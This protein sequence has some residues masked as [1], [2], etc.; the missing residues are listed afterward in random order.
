L[1]FDGDVLLLVAVVIGGLATCLATYPWHGYVFPVGADA[2]VYIWWT[3]LAGQEGLSAV[4]DRPGVPALA[5]ALRTVVP[6]GTAAIIAALEI[7]LT[8]ALALAAAA[9]VRAAGLGRTAWLSVGVLSGAFALHL[10]VG[11]VATLLAAVLVVTA[12]AALSRA[13][14]R[15]VVAAAGLLGVAG[16]A[17]PEFL[18][19]GTVVLGLTAVGSTRGERGRIVAAAL[20]GLAIATLG[21]TLLAI[22]P[23]P[24]DI[25]TS[26]DDVLQ[27]L[28]LGWMLPALFRQRLIEHA[29]VLVPLLTVPLALLGLLRARGFLR[30]VLRSW[31]IVSVIAAVAAFVTGVVPPERFVTFCFALP[32]AAGVGIDALAGRWRRRSVDGA[33]TRRVLGYAAPIAMLGAIATGGL[34]VWFSTPPKLF[35]T[36]VARVTEA[37]RYIASST[38]GTPL[39]FSVSSGASNQ[40]FFA[41]EA[42]NAIRSAVPPDRIRDV[43]IVVAPPYVDGAAMDEEE[44]ALAAALRAEAFASGSQTLWFDLAPF[45]RRAFGVAEAIPEYMPVVVSQGIAIAGS[46]LAPS[47]GPIDPLEEASPWTIAGATLMVFTALSIAGWGWSLWLSG[48]PGPT[49]FA[50]APALGAAALTAGAVIADLL[51]MRLTARWASSI[52]V[53][54]CLAGFVVQRAC[55]PTRRSSE[56]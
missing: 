29:A 39:I 41:T 30:R 42:G 21:L 11:Y 14:R 6:G 2:P 46:H 5:L 35:P 3:R 16:L 15:G 50:L 18:L 52:P 36:E 49:S 10:A 54:V 17:H 19:I 8:L 4:G 45:D 31:V 47:P 48:S 32:I 37:S 38:P 1:H 33:R 55:S 34:I 40:S 26:R 44:R 9:W 22:G 24:I 53:A 12:V 23:H 51:G 7:S 27:R 13:T 25:D 28:G 20:G 56:G 43:R